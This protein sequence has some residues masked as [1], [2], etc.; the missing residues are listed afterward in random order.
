MLTDFYLRHERRGRLRLL[1]CDHL[2]LLHLNLRLWRNDNRLH[3]LVRLRRDD[4]WLLLLPGHGGGRRG[5]GRDDGHRLR[6]LRK[7]TAGDDSGCRQRCGVHLR[8]RRCRHLHLLL[9]QPRYWRR[10]RGRRRHGLRRVH[11]RTDRADRKLMLQL[12]LRLWQ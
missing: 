1:L 11:G 2:C 9:L 3:H 6:N 5:G 12:R 4:D 8:L 10:R 7:L